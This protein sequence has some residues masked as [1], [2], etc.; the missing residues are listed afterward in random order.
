MKESWTMGLRANPTQR[1]RR[2]G[3]EL[4]RL[5]EPTGLSAAE[6][7][8]RIGVGRA[9]MSHIEAGRTHV[10]KEKVRALAETYGCTR[11]ELVEELVAMAASDGRGWW[12]EYKRTVGP[13]LLDLAELESTATG[14]RSFQWLYVPGLLQTRDYMNA[15]FQS[16]NTGVSAD[17]LDRYG[18]FRLKRQQVL[19]RDPAPS[20]HV[21][22][23]E[24][25]FHMGFIDRGIMAEQLESLIEASRSP[26]ITIQILPFSTGTNPAA[27]GAFTILDANAPELRTVYADQPVTS[28]FLGDHDHV[29]QYA[30]HFARLSSVALA[31]L[32]PNAPYGEGTFGLVQYLLYALKEGKR[33]QP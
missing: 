25:V 19:A 24:G 11:H 26:G 22:I 18:E 1:Q 14:Y 3:Q 17:L 27:L 29:E 4:Q 10:S 2:L 5:R 9:H 16:S 7:G 30:G 15:L 13:Q 20:M 28:V 31:P 32:D 21:I 12:S 8:E 6:A 33:V 23:H